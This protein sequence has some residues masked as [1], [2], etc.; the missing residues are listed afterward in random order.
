MD[1]TK[2]QSFENKDSVCLLD[3]TYNNVIV[4]YS[5]QTGKHYNASSVCEA[6]Y[7]FNRLWLSI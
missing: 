5:V 4:G 3:Q 2:S 7:S 1:L 6:D